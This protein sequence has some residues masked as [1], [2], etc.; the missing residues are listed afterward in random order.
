M[1]KK[2]AAFMAAI[3]ASMPAASSGGGSSGIVQT[4]AVDI[5][6]N[7]TSGTG[8]FDAVTTAGNAV[9]IVGYGFMNSAAAAATLT[10]SDDKSS[11]GW[12]IDV[13]VS[14]SSG[15]AFFTFV[16]SNLSVTAGAKVITV[17]S[18]AQFYSVNMGMLEVQGIT[19]RRTPVSY[20]SNGSN[21]A[22]QGGPIVIAN[23]SA[24]TSPRALTLHGFVV[25]QISSNVGLNVSAASGTFVNLITNQD[26]GSGSGPGLCGYI[27]DSATATDSV[28]DAWGATY[29]TVAQALQTFLLA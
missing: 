16:A 27:L 29:N 25:D 6:Q 22:A 9:V 19:G 18:T 26:A 8:S 17:A 15:S 7:L 2:F 20:T 14:P 1:S 4:K 28:T 21:E 5:G 23:A 24:N 12:Q 13:K 3:M 11:S 10:V